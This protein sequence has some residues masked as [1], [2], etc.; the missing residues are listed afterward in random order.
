VLAALDAAVAAHPRVRLLRRPVGGGIVAASNDGLAMADG[1]FVVLLDHD[2][3]LSDDA[4]AL[5]E[6]V[7]R[8]DPQVDYVY[9]DEDKL[10]EVLQILSS[11]V[12]VTPDEYEPFLGGTFI[13]TGEEVKPIWEKA[14]GL[15]SVYGSSTIS[16][17]F[18]V[19]FEDYEKA[20][21]T[22][23]DLDPSLTLEVLAEM[24]K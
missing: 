12:S 2:D 19:N 6:A 23:K 4:L 20:L 15:G 18:N 24:A 21:E 17:E 11:R 10:D 14:E 5:V 13:L 16:N 22:E 3:T 8:A 1:E 7:L 9:S